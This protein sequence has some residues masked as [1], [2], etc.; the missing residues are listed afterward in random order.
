MRVVGLL[1][2]AALLVLPIATARLIARSFRSTMFIAV[3]VGV[4]AVILGLGV[5]RVWGLAPGGTIVLVTIVA[6]AVTSVARPS[7][8]TPT[9]QHDH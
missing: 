6:F 5:A 3:G 2:V 1:L 4:L 9:S 8:A 7:H